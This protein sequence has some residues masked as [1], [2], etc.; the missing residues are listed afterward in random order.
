MTKITY[1][2]LPAKK[3]VYRP[4]KNMNVDRYLYDLQKALSIIPIGDISALNSVIKTITDQHA[5]TKTKVVRGNDKPFMTKEFRKEI[6]KRTHL[7]NMAISSGRAIYWKKYKNQ[8]N[9]CVKSNYKTQFKFYSG[10]DVS[11]IDNNQMFWK[12]IKPLLSDKNRSGGGKIT[13]VENNNI[14][15]DDTLIA[16][17][18]NDYFVNITTKLE[19]KA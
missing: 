4:M 9:H 16:N 18:F 3:I 14:I 10:L 6:M 11:T 8:R 15:S 12:T 19:L 13:L 2:K 17:I 7:K 1:T 5:P